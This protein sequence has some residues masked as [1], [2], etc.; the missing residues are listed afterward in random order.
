MLRSNVEQTWSFLQN[1][2]LEKSIPIFPVCNKNGLYSIR[3]LL[4]F[5]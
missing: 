5:L 1:K 2:F 4:D 3:V